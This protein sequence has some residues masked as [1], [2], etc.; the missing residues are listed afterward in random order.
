M[1]NS[2]AFARTPS[3]APV[4]LKIVVSFLLTIMVGL[5]VGLALRALEHVDLG[6][7]KRVAAHRTHGS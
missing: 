6:I 7:S 2:D 4:H 5:S 1:P 3:T